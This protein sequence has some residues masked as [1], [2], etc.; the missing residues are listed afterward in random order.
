MAGRDGRGHEARPRFGAVVTAMV[1]PFKDDFSLDLPRAQE[2]VAWLLE[3][4]SDSLVVAGTT[5]EG[6][7][8]NDREKVDLWRASVEAAKG[9]GRIIAGTG[10][11]DTAHS[12]H[13]TQE[14]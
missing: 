11:Y 2:L 14:A 6:A 7:T 4:G 13:L 1:T 8:L 10:T 5:G 9:K 12:V 3:R